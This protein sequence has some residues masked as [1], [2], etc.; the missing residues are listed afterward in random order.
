[1]KNTPKRRKADDDGFGEPIQEPRRFVQEVV[2]T[3][4][5][6][7]EEEEVS[8]KSLSVRI[9]VKQSLFPLYLDL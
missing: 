8:I 2:K 3:P 1:M 7:V 5:R 6:P 9:L 4:R